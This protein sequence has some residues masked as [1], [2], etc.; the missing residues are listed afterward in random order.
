MKRYR[1]LDQASVGALCAVYVILDYEG[2]VDYVPVGSDGFV[3]LPSHPN[4]LQELWIAKN[5]MVS[6]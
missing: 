2:A 1:V 5:R 6:G 3:R 4:K